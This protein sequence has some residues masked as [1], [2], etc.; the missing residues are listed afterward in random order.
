MT[1]APKIMETL[2]NRYLIMARTGK[3]K[4]FSEMGIR[5]N[6]RTRLASVALGSKCKFKR[7]SEHN[8]RNKENLQGRQKRWPESD[9]SNN[10]HLDSCLRLSLVLY[11]NCS[12][13]SKLREDY[14]RQS[15]GLLYFNRSRLGGPQEMQWWAVPVPTAELSSGIFTRHRNRVYVSLTPTCAHLLPLPW[16]KLWWGAA[17]FTSLLVFLQFFLSLM[18]TQKLFINPSCWP[19]SYLPNG[20]GRISAPLTYL[21]GRQQGPLHCQTCSWLH[22][23]TKEEMGSGE[24][25]KGRKQLGRSKG[26]I[27]GKLWYHS[28]EPWLSLSE[29][30]WSSSLGSAHLLLLTTQITPS[31][32]SVHSWQEKQQ[33]AAVHPHC[34]VRVATHHSDCSY[35]TEES[36][37]TVKASQPCHWV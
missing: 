1:A 33:E 17:P 6:T 36:Q 23:Q 27:K 5:M 29:K 25:G 16:L 18:G 4:E 3:V 28:S 10:D 31:E 21:G 22:Q 30:T 26:K 20:P 13:P 15:N 32:P 9:H 2:K 8:H 7:V 11:W 12:C 34:L 37:K 35:R 24:C 14:T 19:P